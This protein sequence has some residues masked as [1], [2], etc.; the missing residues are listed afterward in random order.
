VKTFDSSESANSKPS[1]FRDDGFTLIELLVVIAIIAILASLLLPALS[2][3]KLKAM[4]AYCLGNQ[5]QLAL[6]WT[7]YLTDHND[8]MVNFLIVPN[9]N[10]E[11]PWRYQLP[12]KP[13]TVPAGTSPEN[14]LVLTLQEG[15]RQG[16]LFPYASNPGV[17][18]CPADIRI[19]LKVGRGFTYCSLSPIGTLNGETTEFRNST[20]LKHPS[21]RY[22]WVEENDPRGEN[23]GSWI[24][25]AGTPPNFTAA[26]LIDSPAV[27]HGN[28]STFSYADGHS[29]SHK[30]V[31]IATI[32][33]AAS[34][35]PN[36][37]GSRPGGTQTRHDVTW[38]ANQYA[39]RLNP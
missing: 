35:D 25:D 33:Y 1:Q 14:R 36:K 4:T 21:E 32:R 10:N 9:G 2:R 3:A 15:Y 39:T 16:A 6:A 28:S 18:H 34:M 38:L 5:R 19:K 27:F 26:A 24:M 11:I 30:W 22:L 12:P 20:E 37:Y 13:P 31:D 23:L 17:L 7:M 8:K 29:G